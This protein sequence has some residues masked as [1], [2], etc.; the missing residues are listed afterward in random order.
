MRAS[1]K[2]R[3]GPHK[4][5]FQ[6]LSIRFHVH[7]PNFCTPEN[8]RI[9]RLM[10]NMTCHVDITL[11][12]ASSLPVLLSLFFFCVASIGFSTSFCFTMIYATRGGEPCRCLQQ[13]LLNGAPA[14]SSG[15][16][17]SRGSCENRYKRAT[18]PCQS[19]KGF[20]HCFLHNNSCILTDEGFLKPCRL[21]Q[22]YEVF[23]CM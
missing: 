22:E 18:S 3:H 4:T 8:Q 1:R 12:P 6:L 2:F 9:A 16:R 15:P 23:F 5:C 21:H 11:L 14:A 7:Q 20:G 17:V 19:T 13:R 10:D